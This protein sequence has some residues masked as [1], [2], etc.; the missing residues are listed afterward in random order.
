MSLTQDLE[1]VAGQSEIAVLESWLS[2]ELRCE[3]KHTP[4]SAGHNDAGCSILASHWLKSR[5]GASVFICESRAVHM[6]AQMGRG[7]VC[8]D[9]HRSASECWKVV[10]I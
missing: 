9:C 8:A 1:A 5:C 6:V 10:P 2:H 3:S 4:S 7:V